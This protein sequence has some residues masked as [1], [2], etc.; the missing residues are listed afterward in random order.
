MVTWLSSICYLVIDLLG[1]LRRTI[2][3]QDVISNWWYS[4][5]R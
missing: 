1:K 4:H 5:Y 2:V 3:S